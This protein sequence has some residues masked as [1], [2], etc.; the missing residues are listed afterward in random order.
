MKLYFYGSLWS[1][2][3]TNTIILEPSFFPLLDII[4]EKKQKECMKL[5]FLSLTHTLMHAH[6]HTHTLMCSLNSALYIER[7]LSTWAP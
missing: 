6:V 2:G 7:V 3:E 4:L 5:L 1:K